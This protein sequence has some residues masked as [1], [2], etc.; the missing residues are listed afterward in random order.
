VL[1]F[2]FSF[3][4]EVKTEDKVLANKAV[5]AFEDI[6][7]TVDHDTAKVFL[8]KLEENLRNHN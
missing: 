4:F 5:A 3:L 6:F 1:E 2:L 8:K 7:R